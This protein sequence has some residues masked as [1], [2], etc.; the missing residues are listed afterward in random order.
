[1]ERHNLSPQQFL[2]LD[3]ECKILHFLE[4]GYEPFHL[5]GDDGIIDELDEIVA[6]Q[7]AARYP[8]LSVAASAP[9]KGNS[10]GDSNIDGNSN[11][12]DARPTP[13]LL[14]AFLSSKGL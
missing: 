2:E 8:E 1:M 3:C 10:N 6:E 11:G 12:N 13:P 14:D 5:T 9:Q 7:L 4:I